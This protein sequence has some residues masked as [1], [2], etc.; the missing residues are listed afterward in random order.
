MIDFSGA[1]GGISREEKASV[2]CQRKCFLAEGGT[3]PG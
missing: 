2:K 1:F 3:I